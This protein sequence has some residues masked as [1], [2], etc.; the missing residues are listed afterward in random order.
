[1]T[2]DGAASALVSGET[3]KDVVTSRFIFYTC[4]VIGS[5]LVY[6]LLQ[7]RAMALPYNNEYFTLSVFL[8]LCSRLLSTMFSIVAILI[9]GEP[10]TNSAPLW[11]YLALAC[12]SVAVSAFQFES[13][14]YVSFTVQTLGK[15]CKMM[16]VMVWGMLISRKKYLTWQCL[17]AGAVTAGAI[18]FM[19]TGDIQS[20]HQIGNTG[21]GV[22]LT[23]AFL[24]LDGFTSVFQ[25]TLFRQHTT[26]KYNQL[27]YVN[28]GATAVCLIVMLPTG[29]LAASRQFCQAHPELRYDA[30][31]LSMAAVVGQ[32][33][34]YSQ[35]KEFGALVFA[36]TMNVRQVL[37]VICSYAAYGHPIT[38]HQVCGLLI[39]GGAL[40]YQCFMGIG[41]ASQQHS[42]AE[43]EPLF[44][45]KGA[46][47]TENRSKA[48][49]PHQ[50]DV[51]P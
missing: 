35:V 30:L 41:A 23:I 29:F 10:L 45:G 22:M 33:F 28:L 13:L 5:L 50:N 48:K 18:Q 38:N 37:A 32:W 40:L 17:V 9:Q 20:A 44:K 47:A 31:N 25:E 11:K 6:G 21:Y 3:R 24:V 34:I 51:G 42:N 36:A 2:T 19:M 26:S 8:I 15:S 43:N 7:E 1:M 14:K 39:T 16:P 46:A 4:G 27:L 12:S 49:I